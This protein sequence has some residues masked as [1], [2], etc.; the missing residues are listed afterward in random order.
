MSKESNNIIA[1]TSEDYMGFMFF[2]LEK[3]IELYKKYN[4]TFPRRITKT[5]TVNPSLLSVL[6][7]EGIIG[8]KSVLVPVVHM[9]ETIYVSHNM[10]SQDVDFIYADRDIPPSHAEKKR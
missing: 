8:M 7:L 9:G 4:V 6:R 3:S 5:L 1:F 2:N 10:L